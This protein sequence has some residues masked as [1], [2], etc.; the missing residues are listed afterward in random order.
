ME[1]LFF[2]ADQE[3]VEDRVT[4]AVLSDILE[5]DW[6]NIRHDF[7]K[8]QHVHPTTSWLGFGHDPI[9]GQPEDRPPVQ[10]DF[11]DYAKIRGWNIERAW[12]RNDLRLAH[13]S[14]VDEQAGSSLV[15]HQLAAMLQSW[16]YFGLL[17]AIT[18]KMIHTSYLVRPDS[19]ERQLLYSQ[20]L[21][22]CLQAWVEESRRQSLPEIEM[23]L[24]NARN[25]LMAALANIQRIFGITDP[26]S[27][28]RKWLDRNYPGFCE[29]MVMVTPAIIRLT[30]AVGVASERTIPDRDTRMMAFEAPREALDIRNLRLQRRGWCPFLLK[31]CEAN[32]HV[33]VLDWLDGSERH[34]TSGGHADCT[35]SACVRN[36]IDTETYRMQHLRDDCQ[37]SIVKPDFDSVIDAID[38]DQ[39]PVFE[40]NGEPDS[41]SLTVSSRSS[42]LPGDYVAISHVW[43]DGL[44]STTEAG[45]FACQARR[46]GDLVARLSN[47]SGTPLWMDSVCIPGSREH[48]QKSIGLLRNIYRNAAQVLVVDKTIQQ[49]QEDIAAEDLAWSIVCSPW[50]QRL[51]TYQESYLA[52]KTVLALSDSFYALFDSLEDFPES[53]LLDSIQVVRSSLVPILRI[54]RP[55]SSVQGDTRTC[56]GEVASAVNWRTTS[57]AGDEVLAIAALLN[58]DSNMLSCVP[59][60][61]RLRKFFLMVHNVPHD[62]IFHDSS[63]MTETPFRWAPTTLMSRSV[64]NV[65]TTT[66][67]QNGKC[68]SAG[69]KCDYLIL[70]LQQEQSGED[71]VTWYA[72]EQNESSWYSVYWDPVYQNTRGNKFNAVICRAIQEGF[73]LKPEVNVVIEGVAISTGQD[74][75]DGLIC[76]YAGRA[77]M[78]K[79]S[80]DERLLWP[81]DEK[82]IGA[83]WQKRSLCIT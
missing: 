27:K 16:L 78:L 2:Q 79:Y 65:D 75:P 73:I 23:T 22:F 81:Q 51:W 47:Q 29:L 6:T 8:L 13:P 20:N 43:V 59:P 35:G 12:E 28:D 82:I 68:T 48:R 69:L 17:E 70:H 57:K 72:F 3:S 42:A 9:S 15:A 10:R 7:R 56:V 54:L 61:H 41:I 25:N 33:S 11:N 1:H 76:Q 63:R 50:M 5:D 34:N 38:H 24:E 31:Y 40:I 66:L 32:S 53:T 71:D 19:S 67:G 62:I 60:S 58:L 14:F 45:I 64:I 83:E 21:A 39:I 44:G 18:G 77:T 30:D 37:C 52:A 36:N 4:A 49:C 46:L 74:S 80:G 55:D 26:G